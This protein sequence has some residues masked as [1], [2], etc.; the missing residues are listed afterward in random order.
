[1]A[2]TT[3]D[4]P[5]E[6]DVEKCDGEEADVIEGRSN[7]AYKLPCMDALTNRATWTRYIPF[8]PSYDDSARVYSCSKK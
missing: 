3:R 8:L 4:D 6:D 1:M 2:V 7:E 5:G